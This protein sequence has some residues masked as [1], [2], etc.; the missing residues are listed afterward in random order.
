MSPRT[1]LFLCLAAGAEAVVR[2][3]AVTVGRS[4]D[5]SRPGSASGAV[6]SMQAVVAD[7][8][9]RAAKSLLDREFGPEVVEAAVA[10]AVGPDASEGRK[11]EAKEVLDKIGEIASGVASE[12]K[13]R[14]AGAE[15]EAPDDDDTSKL[16]GDAGAAVIEWAETRADRRLMQAGKEAAQHIAAVAEEVADATGEMKAGL[17][18]EASEEAAE[19]EAGEVLK[20]VAH[21]VETIAEAVAPVVDEFLEALGGDLDEDED[22]A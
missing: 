14:N 19:E 21:G 7:E 3:G 20:K 6:A 16:H 17:E 18:G 15:D 1:I 4:A 12:L 9:V 10:G 2:R 11:E 5:G 22:E 8:L 13:E